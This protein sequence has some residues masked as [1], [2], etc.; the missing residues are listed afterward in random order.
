[1]EKGIIIGVNT[2]KNN[3]IFSNE[4]KELKSLCEEA[5]TYGV[6][7]IADI[8]FNHLATNGEYDE[9]GLPV[10]DPEVKQYEPEIY[11]NQSQTFHQEKSGFSDIALNFIHS[12]YFHC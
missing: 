11:D 12:S 9:K 6:K 7:I 10:V 1:M 4:M 2:T 8:I 3:I 5:D